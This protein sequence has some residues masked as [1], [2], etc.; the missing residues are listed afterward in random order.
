MAQKHAVVKLITKSYLLKTL[1]FM[2]WVMIHFLTWSHIRLIHLY[3]KIQP[4]GQT[5]NTSLQI[6]VKTM[7]KFQY[8]FFGNQ[9][10]RMLHCLMLKM[11]HMQT[12]QLILIIIIITNITYFCNIKIKLFLYGIVNHIVSEIIIVTVKNR[13]N[14][15][16]LYN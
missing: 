13:I 10:L 7:L 8:I 1:I 3:F 15:I 5:F 6:L 16:Y 11:F 2:N 9:N 14:L 4:L 12:F